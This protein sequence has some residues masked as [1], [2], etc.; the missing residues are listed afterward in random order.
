MLSSVDK[1]KGLPVYIQIMNMIKKEIMLGNLKDGDQ[2]P[3]VRELSKVF[4]VNTNTVMRAFE[5]LGSEGLVEAQHGVG[6]F[7]HSTSSVDPGVIEETKRYIEVLKRK[8]IDLPMAKM[9]IE[10]VWKSV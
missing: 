3:P 2:L 1:H 7:I 4:D 9:L 6:Y 8:N 5:K 10:E